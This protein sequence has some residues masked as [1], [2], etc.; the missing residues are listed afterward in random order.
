MI[1]VEFL[2]YY[3]CNGEINLYNKYPNC[4]G[5]LTCPMLT[6]EEKTKCYH[7]EEGKA[8]LL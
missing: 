7:Y 3:N 2:K 5:Y 8:D 4:L 1:E 6:E